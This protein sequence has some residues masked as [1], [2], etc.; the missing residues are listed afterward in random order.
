M[1]EI[2]RC[3]PISQRVP[4]P[5][6]KCTEWEL[7]DL[8]LVGRGRVVAQ[9]IGETVDSFVEPISWRTLVSALIDLAFHLTYLHCRF[10]V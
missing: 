5:A 8:S 4:A 10:S 2:N 6:H 3:S 7:C 1:Y 9:T